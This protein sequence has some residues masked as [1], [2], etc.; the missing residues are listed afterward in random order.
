MKKTQMP[1]VLNLSNRVMRSVAGSHSM[2]TP[3]YGLLGFI[4]VLDIHVYV[5]LRS[6]PLFRCPP[7][8]NFMKPES[9][10]KGAVWQGLGIGG[11][12]SLRK[13]EALWDVSSFFFYTSLR[14]YPMGYRECTS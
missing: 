7:R 12:L 10:L 11:P 4:C 9:S 2:R 6:Q 5:Q 8:R 1:P 14:R 3:L 13:K